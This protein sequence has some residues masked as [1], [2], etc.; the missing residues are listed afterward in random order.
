[1]QRAHGISGCTRLSDDRERRK[2][3][4]VYHHLLYKRKSLVNRYDKYF[5][6]RMAKASDVEGI[7]QFIKQ[8]WNAKH[9]L[10]VD[11]DLFKWQFGNH[12][13][14]DREN[15]NV[16]LMTDKS[17]TEILG[18]NGFIKY[19]RNTEGNYISSAM[20]KV[21]SDVRV[22]LSG[23]ELIK[24]FRRLVPAAGEFSSGTNPKTMVPIASKVMKY[25]VGVMQQ[26]YMLNDTIT[27]RIASIKSPVVIRPKEYANVSVRE[28][29]E[30]SGIEDTIHDVNRFASSVQKS[31]EYLRKRYF[32]HPYYTYVAFVIVVEGEY[33]AI[34]F[35][36]TVTVLDSTAFRI[37]DVVGDKESLQFA[38]GYF[39]DYLSDKRLEYMDI[40][41]SELPEDV[42]NSAGLVLNTKDQANIIPHYFEPF[43]RENIDVW[44]Q[45]SD[46]TLTIFKADG[47]QD[48]PNRIAN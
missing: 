25:D 38:G 14:G 24:R 48:R 20:T 23:V 1:M 22:P 9:I 15:I 30:F 39:R 44:F 35:G 32:E 26:Y 45:R 2:Y 8:E 13:Y 47:D 6:F 21:R 41:T 27:H 5:N 3:R 46:P 10:A 17:D 7:M 42:V 36:R 28:E 19:N 31:P 37:V 12:E 11:E 43:A 34:V 4:P 16:V 33:R 40:F 18:I 29:T